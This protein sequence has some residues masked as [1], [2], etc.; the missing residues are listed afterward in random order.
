MGTCHHCEAL[1]W[2]HEIQYE[3]KDK[4]PVVSCYTCLTK[5]MHLI[6][7]KAKLSSITVYV[8]FLMVEQ[9]CGNVEE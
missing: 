5:P 2:M 1:L 7:K 3:D 8:S 4:K 6:N 9:L